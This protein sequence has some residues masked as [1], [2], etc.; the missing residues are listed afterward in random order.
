MRRL[1]FVLGFVLF[2]VLASP[3][4]AAEGGRLGVSS[5]HSS[6][7]TDPLLPPEYLMDD[8][9]ATAWGLLPGAQEGWVEL[10]LGGEA[11]IYGLKID[12]F[13]APDTV[14]RL[15]YR[16]GGA[17]RPFLLGRLGE[18]P[19]DGI[20]DLSLDRVVAD[21]LR[22]RLSGAGT[23]FSRLAELLI[24]GTP[25]DE[26]LFRLGPKIV[27]SSMN[28]LPGFLARF[29]IDGNTRTSW[30]AR[31]RLH[32]GH[33]DGTP[34]ILEDGSRCLPWG[35]GRAEAV[36]DLGESYLL[37]S[38]AIYLSPEARGLIL[39]QA[40]DGKAYRELGRLEANGEAGWKRIEL[41]GVSARRLRLVVEGREEILGGLGE[42]VLFG[43]GPYP[44]DRHEPLL[45]GEE[46][47]TGP[48]NLEFTVE[49]PRAG[50]WF[51]EFACADSLS[52]PLA[53]DLNGREFLLAPSLILNGQ[54]LYELRLPEEVLFR[55]ANFLRI[56]PGSGRVLGAAFLAR[57]NGE[58]I[59]LPA[60]GLS[61]HLLLTTSNTTPEIII[62]L[63]AEV[64]LE[65]VRVFA[66]SG[67]GI[68]VYAHSKETW[69]P[70]EKV[71]SGFPLRFAGP[72]LAHELRILNPYGASLSEVVLLGSPT[73]DGPPAVKILHP[74]DGACLPMG[75][76]GREEVLG[77]V[78]DPGCRV[79]VNG[80]PVEL[81]GHFFRLKL[82]A[83]HPRPWETL[84]VEAVARDAQG[85]EGRDR[86][87]IA[88][89][90]ADL[91]ELDGPEWLVR[92]TD[93]THTI[94][95]RVLR[96]GVKVEING[97]E[98][99]V[100]HGRFRVEVPLEEGFNRLT[101]TA[102][103]VSPGGKKEF[104]QTVTRAVVRESD[105]IE[106]VVNSPE[107][108]SYL[109]AESVAV[110][111]WVKG[112]PPI[113]LTVNGLPAEISPDGS[114]RSKPIPLA[115][116]E[117][118]IAIEARTRDGRIKQVELVVFADRTPPLVTLLEP[119]EGAVL[120]T[121][122][123]KV[124]GY[125][126]E[127]N[128]AFL[129]INGRA[130][131]VVNGEFSLVLTLPEGENRISIQA[132]DLAGN[133][134]ALTRTV[135]VDLTPPMPFAITV[136]PVG[137]Y[138]EWIND[139]RPT[140]TFATTD[141]GSGV[142]EYYIRLDSDA[143]IGPV[144]SPYRFAE[145]LPD[146]A[147]VVEVEAVDYAGW[148]RVSAPLTVKID[149]IPPEAPAIVRVIPGNGEI[150]VAWKLITEPRTA[151]GTMP[152][153]PPMAKIIIERDPVFNENTVIELDDIKEYIDVNLTNG[154]TYR[155]R[156]KA[157]D[158]AGNHGNWSDWFSA[159]V[160]FTVV[161][162]NNAVGST[163]EYSG[164]ALAIPPGAM[165]EDK[166]IIIT[167][168]ECP[169]LIDDNLNTDVTK[170]PSVLPTGAQLLVSPIYLVALKDVNTGQ[171]EGRDIDKPMIAKMSYDPSL[172]PLEFPEQ[173]LA[174]YWY[175]PM[176]SH[177]FKVPSVVDTDKNEVLF[178]TTHF[179]SAFSVQ[180]SVVQDLSPEEYRE[181]GISPL[182][183]Y[184]TQGDAN[185]SPMGGT[186]ST[187]AVD[188]VLPGKDGDALVFAR[189]YDGATAKSDALG[190]EISA[191]KEIRLGYFG[192]MQNTDFNMVYEF[193]H[194][195]ERWGPGNPVTE[196]VKRVVWAYLWC[197]GDAAFSPG[198]GWRFEFPYIK[199][200]ESSAFLRMPNG[201]MYDIH[202]ATITDYEVVVDPRFTCAARKLTLDNGYFLDRYPQDAVSKANADDQRKQRKNDKPQLLVGQDKYKSDQDKG[203]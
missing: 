196:L 97:T 61:D 17:W 173:N 63:G 123:V 146:G 53:V 77:F 57:R 78:D 84:T 162:Y 127:A 44:G 178:I 195:L 125:L 180:A 26:V 94:S 68:E 43:T 192:S 16:S 203:K 149:T 14:L 15:E 131:E 76:I 175:D 172:I 130:A 161:Q 86:I 177:W 89:G 187:R 133:T 154:N 159:T 111:G 103:F 190:L 80:L 144:T 114:F 2:F 13:L 59:T 193:V 36:F 52:D 27:G 128:P 199:L 62:P 155:Y 118:R 7:T 24:L 126:E 6:P 21:G 8:D 72:I 198:Q 166:Q 92:T 47:L 55:G 96:P 88:L 189:T 201:S 179:S 54:T 81:D 40:E 79:R 185:V 58:G 186:L 140:F 69:V 4:R 32:P 75:A 28:T 142:K 29:L 168:I 51:L 134:A 200:T 33:R 197:Q 164:F 65:E 102:S 99:P 147:H 151:E 121:A 129:L 158:L 143:W 3:V 117:N 45:H 104:R 1:L 70:L 39:L 184:V 90:E 93:D 138:T 5:L 85:R 41:N 25:R 122:E 22:L 11:L 74:P 23:S 87:E 115:E 10:A 66:E 163:A 171:I 107:D 95:G 71:N 100:V 188:L 139:N 108:G 83:L 116:G 191:R 160:G 82:T 35:E 157:I 148:E 64:L 12:G 176:F 9:P 60:S 174:V 170:Q 19:P 46:T 120:N 153:D 194:N 98:V 152:P 113:R 165:P 132:R 141:A 169:E 167:E 145:P 34:D 181:V 202:N 37:R 91:I 119:A 38:A 150:K 56:K 48:L 106:V 20:I 18:L 110:T 124:K 67:E 109:K 42:L 105:E 135:T 156:I 112:P 101:V 182:K 50:G 49:D 31:G 136:H 30:F 183:S 73:T 137:Q